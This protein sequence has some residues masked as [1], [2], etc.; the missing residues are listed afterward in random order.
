MGATHAG[1]PGASS[2]PPGRPRA[3]E[4][5]LYGG[6]TVGVLD[7]VAVYF[8]MARA[9]VPLSAARTLPLSLTQIVIHVLFVGLPVAL[10]A[11]RSA[12]AG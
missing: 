12:G 7:G 6:L 9:V 8:V 11:R 3:F 5:I 10:L 2:A 1:P 4:A